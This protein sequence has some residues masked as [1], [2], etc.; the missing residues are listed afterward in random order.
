MDNDQLR[1]FGAKFKRFIDSLD[2]RIGAPTMESVKRDH[3]A[4]EY[5]L[6]VE[7]I[8]ASVVKEKIQL[9]TPEQQ[10]L[11]SFAEQMSAG[12]EFI[13]PFLAMQPISDKQ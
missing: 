11:R 3:N 1:E 6:A 10:Q 8:L 12:E 13:V 5:Q 7:L 9:S 4:G 2:G